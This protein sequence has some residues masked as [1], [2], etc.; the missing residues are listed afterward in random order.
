MRRSLVVPALLAAVLTVSACSSGTEARRTVTVVN[1]VTSSSGAPSTGASGSQSSIVVVPPSGSE[2]AATTAPSGTGSASASSSAPASTSASSAPASS[3]PAVQDVDPLQVA[4]NVILAPA[5]VKKALGATIS[6]SS[7]RIKDVADPERKI[8]G[9]VRCRFGATGD[10]AGK[11]TAILTTYSSE[12]AAADQVALT[13]SSEEDLGAKASSV[14]VSGY[15]AEI[16]LREGGLIVVQYG[17]WTLT[18]VAAN[19]LASEAELEEGLPELARLA[20][21]R[22]VKNG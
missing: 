7:V 4:C 13:K 6:A 20:L 14:E 9:K 21:A 16:L 22:V 12:A 8:T 15:P 1:T 18:L 17:D 10:E 5:D 2:S 19:G 3:T 11:V